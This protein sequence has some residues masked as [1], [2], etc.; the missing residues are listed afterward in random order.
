MNEQNLR[1]FCGQLGIN[2]S[3][4]K[5][6]KGWIEAPC[7]L[8]P[9]LHAKRVDH[10]PSFAVC[11]NNTGVSSYKCH[12]C[13]N[14]GTFNKL[15]YQLARYRNDPEI[16]IIAE[17]IQRQE[18]R[19]FTPPDWDDAGEGGTS[20]SETVANADLYPSYIEYSF[21]K[22]YVAFRGI[23]AHTALALGLRAD[24]HR[25]R[26]LFPVYDVGGVFR[27]FSGRAI[28]FSSVPDSTKNAW[29]EAE[30]RNR[31]KVRDYLG[32]PKRSLLLG[33]HQVRVRPGARIILVEGLFA[34]ARLRQYGIQNVVALLGSS[35]TPEKI[36]KLLQWSLPVVCLLDNDQAGQHGIYGNISSD[37]K[38]ILGIVDFLQGRLPL[39]VPTWPEGKTDPDEL[40]RIEVLE[41]VRNAELHL[42]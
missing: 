15:A 13:H 40:T 26:V 10:N 31:P 38:R 22:D 4:Y 30:N 41:I 34:Y 11:V 14:Q 24:T 5:S 42:A 19:G 16:K 9:W 23:S 36:A 28:E 33:E 39:L 3:R 29:A 25:G 7:P 32:L 12:T 17:N 21:A 27:G 6:S 37:G 8:A 18:I 20:R 35:P 1:T 2:L